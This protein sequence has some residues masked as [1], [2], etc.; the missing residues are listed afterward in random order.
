MVGEG[1]DTFD[2][3]VYIAI[4]WFLM[5]IISRISPGSIL[6]KLGYFMEL[7]A[8]WLTFPGVILHEVSHKLCCDLAGI[9]VQ[10]AKYFSLG[11]PMG[12]VLHDKVT[13]YRDAYLITIGPFIVN[14]VFAMAMFVLPCFSLPFVVDI[15]FLWLGI[16]FAVR[17]M[18]GDGESQGL[19]R[20]SERRALQNPLL[21]LGY[22]L[23]IITTFLKPLKKAIRVNLIYAAVLY[24]VTFCLVAMIMIAGSA[25]F[26]GAYAATVVS[27]DASSGENDTPGSA[28][29]SPGLIKP[30]T[31]GSNIRGD[32]EGKEAPAKDW[33]S[34]AQD[35][36][37]N[38]NSNA[39]LIAVNGYSS[40]GSAALPINGM[41]HRWRYTFAEKASG[42]AYDI[43][44]HDGTF[45]RIN[46]K[47]ISD[48]GIEGILYKY[49]DPT[50]QSWDLDST[51]AVAI[52]NK[53]FKEMTG[54]D[55]PASA[56]YRLEINTAGKLTWTIYN[57]D[58]T[59]RV[60]ANIDVDPSTGA[61]GHTFMPPS[62]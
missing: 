35:K 23:V 15:I 45:E 8:G 34:I 27:T 39:V 16:S 42:Q 53:K 36:M 56:G 49:G 30:T 24:S 6:G 9:R 3:F 59:S 37:K 1:M 29:V 51:D 21:F 18:P 7:F 10:E 40:E 32:I 50:I 47:T 28:S 57:Y 5:A 13:R 4:V 14:T 31:T 44:V 11:D 46:Q 12:Y 62:K 26:P 33:L 25:V 41:S 22:P 54:M 20:W 43:Y 58:S 38:L 55:A 60:I 52:S 48:K 2:L 17:A 19:R 61:I